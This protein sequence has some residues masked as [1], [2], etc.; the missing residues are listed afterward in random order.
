MSPSLTVMSPT[1]NELPLDLD[2]LGA[3]DGRR[4]PAA[5]DDR[6]V[7]DEAAAGG[8]DA[9]A[10]HHPVDVLRAGLAADEDDLLA[11]LVGVD[12]VVGGEVHPAD[13]GARRRGEALGDDLALAG[14]LRVQHL[15]EVLGGDAHQRLVL[16]DLPALVALAGALRHLDG[17]PQRG[18]AGALADAGLQHPQL[19]LLD[20][21]LGVAHVAVVPL[22]A[23][24][25][26]HQ[27]GVDRRELGLQRVEVLG[28]AD[29][30]DDVLALRV[31]EE[32][33]VRLVLAGG[34]VAGEADAGAAVVV[35]VAEHHRLHVDR[36]AEVVADPLADAVGDRAGA[37]PAAEHGLD[38]AAQLLRRVLRER[39]AGVPS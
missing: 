30:G 29:A 19:A 1:V 22:E 18:R 10:D 16:A 35:A 34:R 2:R 21:E 6:G 9:L 31:D 4:A 28:V 27:L 20:G 37:V 23:V 36:G 8:E 32:V 5:G 25:D 26:V 24:E 14:E 12:R 38:R 7:A 15:V 17:H 13:G 39:L 11:A 3:D 33:A